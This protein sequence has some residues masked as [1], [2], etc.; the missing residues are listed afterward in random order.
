MSEHEEQKVRCPGCGRLAPAMR[1]C[2]YCGTKLPQ[3]APPLVR[4]GEPLPPVP[5]TVPPPTTRMQVQASSKV[6][7]AGG[8]KE[9]AAALMAEIAALYERRVALLGLFQSNQ[10]S[11]RVFLKLYRE[12]SERLS[13]LL[14]KRTNMINEL[15]KSL[16]EKNVR[17]S[18]IA[19]SLEEIEIRRKVGEI[20]AETFSQKSEG[21]K[22]E[23][24]N[25]EESIKD[26]R[27]EV[28]V[29]EKILGQKKAADILSM[30]TNLKAF[31]E[32]LEKSF[33]DGK[34]SEETYNIVKP[35]IDDTLNLL[36]SL[37][38]ERKEK[39]KELRET[40]E[41]LQT[42]YKLGELSLEEF[43]KTKREIHAEI[44]KIWQ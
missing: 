16:D 36:E 3:Y 24:K 28:E 29:L 30:E 26:L 43:E 2:I 32:A 5:P 35:G 22:A 18:E 10:V 34:I 12:Y 14:S 33:R 38:R 23:Q 21:L 17:L 42:R 40:L 6:P 8:G 9:E 13:G 19:V 41:T 27:A 37:T 11:E 7:P 15:K 4:P 44:D 31:K 25:L 20:D 1:Y 39:E